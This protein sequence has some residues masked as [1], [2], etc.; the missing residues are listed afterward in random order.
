MPS[1]RKISEP[2]GVIIDLADDSGIKLR[3]AYELM[4]REAGGRENLFFTERDHANHL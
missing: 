1:Q 3:E 2:Y 4:G